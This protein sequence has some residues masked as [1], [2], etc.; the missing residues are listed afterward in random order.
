M[1]KNKAVLVNAALAGLLATGGLFSMTAKALA[2]DG[3]ECTGI[4]ACKGKGECGGAGSSCAGKNECKGKGWV[5]KGSA[6]ECTKA[7]G[8]VVSKGAKPEETKPAK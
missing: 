4:N 5:K 3:V 1:K 2:A 8:K 6:E 7:G